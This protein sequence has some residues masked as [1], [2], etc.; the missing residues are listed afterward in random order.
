MV[1][2]EKGLL[3][4][5]TGDG[6][7][8]TTAAI[9]Q[10]IRAIGHGFKVYM[11][12]FMKGKIN[13]GELETAKRLYPDFIIEQ[14]GRPEFVSREKPEEIDVELAKKALRRA[15]PEGRNYLKFFI[16]R[17]EFIIYYYRCIQKTR[18]LGVAYKRFR[19]AISNRRE[20][21]A[22]E[23]SRRMIRLADEAVKLARVALEAYAREVRDRSDLG[24]LAQ[25]NRDM[26]LYL[27]SLKHIL[28]LEAEY[29]HF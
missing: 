15:K 3:Q 4:V 19:E 17:L 20:K 14:F 11:V 18:E 21:L 9:G 25:M 5:Y 16:S 6:K 12:Q 27:K 23:F 22:R 2:L 10:A 24:S 1:R 28:T 13:Y 7:G 8:K 29:W 26:Y